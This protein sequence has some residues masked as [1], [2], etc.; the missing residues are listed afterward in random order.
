MVGVFRIIVRSKGQITL[1]QE[2]REALGLRE[3]S[4]LQ[5]QLD[6]NRIVME[7]IAK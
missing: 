4:I 7:V 6:G 1:P 5:L 2:V 3:G